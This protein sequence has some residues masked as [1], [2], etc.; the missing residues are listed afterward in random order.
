MALAPGGIQRRNP[1]PKCGVIPHLIAGP[2]IGWELSLNYLVCWPCGLVRRI[3]RGAEWEPRKLA[4][5][6]GARKAAMQS[7]A[8]RRGA[9]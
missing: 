4:H 7:L 1:C 6:R 3:V 8:E 5:I 2:V 9:I